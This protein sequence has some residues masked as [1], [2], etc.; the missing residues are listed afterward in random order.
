MII[1]HRLRYAGYFF[2]LLSM[3][4]AAT[5][6]YAQNNVTISGIVKEKSGDPVIGAI[7]STKGNNPR[8]TIADKDGKFSL[9]VPN[10]NNVVLVVSFLGMITKEVPATPGTPVTVTLESET[11]NMSEVVVVGYGQ[12]KKASVVGAIVQTTG[13]VLERTGGVTN[14]G[15]ALTGNLPG[16]VT[17]SSSGAPGGEDPQITIDRK[18]V[19]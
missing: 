12:Q 14:L 7:I 10:S 4:F 3:L 13:K 19:V 15:M 9:S 1:N 11:R 6:T 2:L 5:S 16:L 8:R 17:Q 18:S